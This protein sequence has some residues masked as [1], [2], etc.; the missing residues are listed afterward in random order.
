MPARTGILAAF[1]IGGML[2]LWFDSIPGIDVSA[3]SKEPDNIVSES[4]ARA[5]S[6]GVGD[7]LLLQGVSLF[8]EKRLKESLELLSRVLRIGE[9]EH[10][11]RLQLLAINNM[12]L[13]YFVS[14]EYARALDY[15]LRAYEI[16]MSGMSA[17]Y[18]LTMLNNIALV[19][20]ADGQPEKALGFV[21]SAYRRAIE[22]ELFRKAADYG[23]NL[24]TIYIVLEQHEK[25]RSILKEAMQWM[26]R[27]S[28]SHYLASISLAES[29]ELQ[30]NHEWSRRILQTI[31]DE[32]TGESLDSRGIAHNRLARVLYEMGLNEEAILTAE[33]TVGIAREAGNIEL[34][35]DAVSRLSLIWEARENYHLAYEYLQQSVDLAQTILQLRNQEKLTELQA[36][37]ELSKYEYELTAAEERY[38]TLR[39]F[40]A[41]MATLVIL[42]AILSV[43]AFRIKLVN[44]RQKNKLLQ[45]K[46]ESAA[47]REKLLNEEIEMKNKEISSKVLVSAAKNDMIHHVIQKIEKANHSGEKSLYDLKNELKNTLDID[48]D[49]N[50]FVLHF[51]QTHA[52][53]FEKLLSRHSDLN[54]ND[55]R[56]AAYLKI[57]LG[58]KEIARLLNITPASYRKRKMRLKAKLGLERPAN[59]EQYISNF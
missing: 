29:Y 35:H 37:F 15:F 43:Y 18:E 19:Y 7:S 1:L 9:E 40:F 45:R 39:R 52:R 2:L 46:E 20:Q 55:L 11:D 14:A 44:M 16:S 50:D 13:C 21:E 53:F 17:H 48:R 30:G 32:D 6:L 34:E 47:L 33:K 25:A 3:N 5:K 54:N 42:I 57:N 23:V 28:D 8:E 10:D 27:D 24:G 41:G 51:E 38:D 58:G 22:L 56:F 59:L 49:W 31:I 12:G 4:I 26:D 36:R